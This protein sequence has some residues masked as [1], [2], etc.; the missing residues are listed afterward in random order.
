[1]KRTIFILIIV[2][3]VKIPCKSQWNRL[4]ISDSLGQISDVQFHN[5]DT[6]YLC[7]RYIGSQ[8]KYKKNPYHFIRTTDGGNTMTEIDSSKFRIDFSF[9][10]SKSGIISIVKDTTLK[11]G[12]APY[13]YKMYRT[14]DAGNTWDSLPNTKGMASPY[15]VTEYICFVDKVID[16]A[17]N[18]Q[19]QKT[20]DGGKTWQQNDNI[21]RINTEV[22]FRNDTLHGY[23]QY[24][25]FDTSSGK[26]VWYYE[27]T[28]DAGETWQKI[29]FKT[30]VTQYLANIILSDKVWLLIGAIDSNYS[31]ITYD[32]GNSWNKYPFHIP[33]ASN[34]A[35]AFVDSNTVFSGAY[36]AK[37]RMWKTNDGTKTWGTQQIQYSPKRIVMLDSNVGY[38][39]YPNL[40]QDIFFTTNGGGT[41]TGLQP[42][43]RT[44]PVV[45]I[46]PNPTSGFALLIAKG[47]KSEDAQLEIT[48]IEG[49][50]LYT[51]K[52]KPFNDGNLQQQL[53]LTT[54]PCGVYLISLSQNEGRWTYRLVVK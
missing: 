12:T 27:R 34:K 42:P 15:L 31:Y 14:K 20:K 51:Q 49:K 21:Q 53:D 48:T 33:S 28:N 9:I 45:T 39:Y 47:L 50:R 46:S 32:D 11:L 8:H 36:Y 17:G 24:V 40:T 54:Y 6:G 7:T 22:L 18:K 29:N 37:V 10:N 2:I 35:F 30:P 41:I 26:W 19:L 38:C 13:N 3:I 25:K 5:S 44:S 4:P 23:A 52:L 16:S 1:M 43:T